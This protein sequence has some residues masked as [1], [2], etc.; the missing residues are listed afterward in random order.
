MMRMTNPE[1]SFLNR[2]INFSA[3]KNTVPKIRG[4]KIGQE[5]LDEARQLGV[6]VVLNGTVLG[7]YA[8]GAINVMVKDRL[9][10]VKG[11]KV[12]IATG[13]SENMIPFPGWTL[14]GVIGAGAAQT[15]QIFMAS[16]LATG[17]W[18]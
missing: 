10:Q 11:E 13:A 3:Q 16:N 8:N 9:E 17:Y 5:L 2:Y 18:L 12:L 15:W 6:E 4:I 7:I 14:P 1:G